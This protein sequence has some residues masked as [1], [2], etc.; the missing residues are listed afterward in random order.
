M[1][2]QVLQRQARSLP[3][4]RQNA[5]VEEQEGRGTIQRRMRSP[6]NC[7]RT[8]HLVFLYRLLLKNKNWYSGRADATDSLAADNGGRHYLMMD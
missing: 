6:G 3:W 5:K 4:F 7:S 2:C 8:A 1:T